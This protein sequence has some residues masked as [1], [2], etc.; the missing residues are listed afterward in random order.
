MSIAGDSAI[1]AAAW[2]AK[3]LAA[4]VVEPLEEWQL[5]EI[6][7]ATAYVGNTLESALRRRS[8]V[9]V[10]RDVAGSHWY[11]DRIELAL[12]GIPYNDTE[13]A[14]AFLDARALARLEPE[15]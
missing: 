15:A 13:R 10:A 5:R 2:R 7:W 9:L 4:R 6:A 12:E 1:E 3:H 11:M 8:P 14:G